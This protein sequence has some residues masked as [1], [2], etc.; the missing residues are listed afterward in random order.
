MSEPYMTFGAL[1]LS[2]KMIDDAAAKGEEVNISVAGFLYVDGDVTADMIKEHVGYVFVNG[3]ILG[4]PE[5]KELLREKEAACAV[6]AAN[7]KKTAKTA[8]TS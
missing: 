2:K 8:G 1:R 7:G 6:P 5:V 4:S 3:M